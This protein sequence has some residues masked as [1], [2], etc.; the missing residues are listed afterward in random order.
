MLKS[1]ADMQNRPQSQSQEELE[2]EKRAKDS[3]K[4]P[5]KY[6]Y[7]INRSIALPTLRNQLLKGLLNPEIDVRGQA[8]NSAIL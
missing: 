8:W 6:S 1:Y 7:K 4:K 2:E 3:Q 5:L